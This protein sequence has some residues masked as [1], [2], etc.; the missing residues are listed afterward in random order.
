M[1][2]P[3]VSVLERG[4]V[5]ADQGCAVAGA[6]LDG[7]AVG[8]LQADEELRSECGGL[9]V[10]VVARVVAHIVLREARRQ[11]PEGQGLDAA[12]AANVWRPKGWLAVLERLEPAN[13]LRLR[14]FGPVL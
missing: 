1:V 9:A 2:E 7:V 12:G 13:P 14:R 6:E 5:T 11:A 8:V 4:V 3:Q 10:A